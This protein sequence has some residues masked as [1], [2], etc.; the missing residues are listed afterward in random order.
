MPRNICMCQY[1]ENI[2]LICDCLSKKILEFPSYSG[3]F[4]DHLVCSSGNEECMLG[5][6]NKCSNS[7]DTLIEETALEESAMWY[8]WER[9][10]VVVPSA[11]KKS[12]NATKVVRKM[13][14]IFKEGTIGDVVESL[15]NKIPSFLQHVFIKRQQ[16]SYFQEKL[17]NLDKEEAVVQVDFAENYACR[18]QDEIQSAHWHQE[19]VTL[20]TVAVWTKGTGGED[21]V[22]ESH[23]MVSDEMAHDKKVVA[24]FMSRVIDNFVTKRHPNVKQVYVFSDGPSSQFKNKYMADFV[25]T[26]CKTVHIQ[27][28]FFATSH[29]K[30]VVDGTGGTVKRLVWNAVMTR[31]S[32]VV[33]DD[34]QSFFQVA[35]SLQSS[36]TVSPLK[37]KEMNDISDSLHL[38]KCFSEALPIPGISRFH[39]IEPGRNSLSCFLYSFQSQMENRPPD[40]YPYECDNSVSNSPSEEISDY[41]EDED[42]SRKTN[43]NKHRSKEGKAVCDSDSESPSGEISESDMEEESDDGEDCVEFVRAVPTQSL[44]TT[45][46][47]S[48]SKDCDVRQGIPDELLSLFTK[49]LSFSLPYYLSTQVQAI[50]Q[51][52]IVFSGSK[53]I[54][55]NDLQSLVG[56]EDN[57]QDKWLTNFVIDEYFKLIQSASE[58]KNVKVKPLSWEIFEKGQTLLVARHLQQ[59]ESPFIQDLILLPCNTTHSKHWFLVVVLPKKKMVIALDSVAGDFVKPTTQKALDKMGS[60]LK[61]VDA[62]CNLDEWAFFCNSKDDIPQ[63]TNGYDCGVYTCLYARCLAGYGPM[64]KEECFPHLRECMLFSLHRGI[65]HEIPLPAIVL[66]EYYAVDYLN[67]YYIGRA[68]SIANQ[69]VKFKFLHRVFDRYVWPGRDDIDNVHLPCVFF[70]SHCT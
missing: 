4:V 70:W 9:V 46:I 57:P 61:A 32:P 5:K 11:S 50:M 7:L 51:G 69:L 29:G 41:N 18:Y 25:Q 6:C 8:E 60:V 59:D 45:N 24:V 47:K 23:G 20:F 40:V 64:I 34:A 10:E 48:H 43:V 58:G 55:L 14:K 37:Q 63:Q 44:S 28:N 30:G 17:T 49:N 38:E 65:L 3:N 16:S 2:K 33:V 39:C 66:E 15:Q 19:Q 36:V 54:S 68:L 42:P 56:N 12:S 67:K 13:K 53:L 21:N 35:N 62:S 22:C 27:W 26:L 1:H 31:K 52:L